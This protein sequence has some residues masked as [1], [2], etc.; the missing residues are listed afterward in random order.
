MCRPID[1]ERSAGHLGSIRDLVAEYES[2]P[3][4]R[5]RLYRR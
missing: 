4:A 5:H 2:L 3:G 1:D